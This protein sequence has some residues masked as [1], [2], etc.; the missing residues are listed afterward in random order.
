M[1]N[2]A[3]WFNMQPICNR[4]Q[5]SGKHWTPTKYNPKLIQ[6][7]I[8][9]AFMIFSSAYLTAK[10][11]QIKSLSFWPHTQKKSSINGDWP[12]NMCEWIWANSNVQ[13]ALYYSDHPLRL[14]KSEIRRICTKRMNFSNFFSPFSLFSKIF[15]HFPR[16]S[17]D[18]CRHRWL[19]F[20]LQQLW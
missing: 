3:T 17:S 14:L 4:I 9:Y 8:V 11:W 5:T 18:F 13:F 12:R 16:C 15:W 10:M 2:I 1:E 19:R 20:C 7:N 6:W